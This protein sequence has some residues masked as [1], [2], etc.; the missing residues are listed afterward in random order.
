MAKKSDK[1]LKKVLNSAESLFEKKNE[2]ATAV[3]DGGFE[4]EAQL[5]AAI[6]EMIKFI[7]FL[8][9]DYTEYKDLREEELTEIEE[10]QEATQVQKN[11]FG[12]ID[13]TNVKKEDEDHDPNIW[14]GVL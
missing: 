2:F 9:D 3:M 5:T 8:D 12:V 11:L 10:Q 6:T 1:A 14:N 4:N 13:T 7:Q